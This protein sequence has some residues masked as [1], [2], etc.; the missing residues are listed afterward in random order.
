M[1]RNFPVFQCFAEI[2]ANELLYFLLISRTTNGFTICSL[3]QNTS[4]FKT[5]FPGERENRTP[6]R[7]SNPKQAVMTKQP[8]RRCSQKQCSHLAQYHVKRSTFHEGMEQQ[9]T[10]RKSSC[11]TGIPANGSLLMLSLALEMQKA[12]RILNKPQRGSYQRTCKHMTTQF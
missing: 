1:N 9:L 4:V 7:C 3:N 2:S 12:G 5:S 6:L 8:S 11:R 10:R